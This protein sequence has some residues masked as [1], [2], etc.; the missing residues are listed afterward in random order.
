MDD[1][2]KIMVLKQKLAA[3]KKVAEWFCERTHSHDYC[4][5]CPFADH[6]CPDG[7]SLSPCQKGNNW[8]S[9]LAKYFE[10]NVEEDEVPEFD[11][12]Y[13]DRLAEHFEKNIETDVEED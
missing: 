2:L 11:R 9:Y 6:C 13:L 7:S 5:E 10:T 8:V 12:E 3:M 4:G 1:K